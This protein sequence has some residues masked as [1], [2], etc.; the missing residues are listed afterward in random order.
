MFRPGSPKVV[1]F[2]EFEFQTSL[3]ERQ[4]TL[5]IVIEEVIWSIWGSYQNNTR[6]H[7]DASVKVRPANVSGRFVYGTPSL[8][9]NV[10]YALYTV[11]ISIYD[12]VTSTY[13]LV[14]SIHGAVIS[15]LGVVLSIYDVCLS[16]YV[17]VTSICRVMIPI[18]RIIIN[19]CILCGEDDMWYDD[20]NTCRGKI[21]IWCGYIN[22]RFGRINI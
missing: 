16:I 11:M 17:V 1:R 12:V 20:I 2:P 21:D 19:I 18:S 8:S 14:I 9:Y 3:G 5:V 10:V 7:F 22:V 13:Y 6:K 15:L 4:G